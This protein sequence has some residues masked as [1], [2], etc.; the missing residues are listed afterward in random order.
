[1]TRQ[2]PVP[3]HFTTAGDLFECSIFVLLLERHNLMTGLK[4]TYFWLMKST[5]ST[6]NPPD[7]FSMKSTNLSEIIRETSNVSR[8]KHHLPRKVTPDIYTVHS[9]L[10]K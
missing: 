5:E 4:K 10:I 9:M 6:V 1:M 8:A 2:G 7:F 3:N